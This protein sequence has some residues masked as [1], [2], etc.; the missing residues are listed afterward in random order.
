VSKMDGAMQIVTWFLLQLTK[1][2]KD[3]MDFLTTSSREVHNDGMYVELAYLIC[4]AIR[5]AILCIMAPD[6]GSAMVSCISPR[7]RASPR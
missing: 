6:V 3:G 4:R 2:L 1:I 5:L 7:I